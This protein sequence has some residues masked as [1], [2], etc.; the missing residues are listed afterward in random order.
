MSKKKGLS[1]EGMKHHKRKK[2]SFFFPRSFPQTF[3][4]QLGRSHN[5]KVLSHFYSNKIRKSFDQNSFF[6]KNKNRSEIDFNFLPFN[7]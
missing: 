1:K 3:F 2:K 4:G 5:E 7:I 6:K